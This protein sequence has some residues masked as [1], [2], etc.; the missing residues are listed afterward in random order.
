[1]ECPSHGPPLIIPDTPVAPGS[2]NRAALT[3]PS[4]LEL[5]TEA[6]EVDVRCTDEIFP[7]GVV[8]GPY[9]GEL[10]SKDESSSFSWI[11]SSAGL[12]RGPGSYRAS[13]EGF[14][15]A[16]GCSRLLV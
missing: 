11:V 9:E 16:V 10:V 2:A 1:M 15:F 3:I 5:L 8:F 12:T 4:G 13:S 14:V 7:K 6:E